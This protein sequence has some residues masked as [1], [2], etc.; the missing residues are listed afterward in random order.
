MNNDQAIIIPHSLSEL[1]MLI[2]STSKD[3]RYV[4]GAT[5]LLVN[6]K[7][8]NKDSTPVDLTAVNE[9]AGTIKSYGSGL[10]IG[11]AVPMSCIIKHPEIRRNFPL[12]TVACSQIGSVQIQNRATLGGNIANASPAGDTLPVL[13]VYDAELMIGPSR[14]DSYKRINLDRMMTAPGQTILTNNRYIAYIYLPLPE[15]PDMFAYF[16]KVGPRHAMAI[17]KVSLAMLCIIRD[18]KVVH[19]RISAGSVTPVIQRAQLTEHFLLG[20]ELNSE[21]IYQARELIRTEIDPID[22]I[23]STRTYR[24]QTCA[25]LLMEALHHAANF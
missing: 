24:S 18:N 13:C 21:T 17:S 6:G 2:R 25:N 12:L 7:W 16:R 9:L 3:I 8:R 11:A 4:A 1:D 5:D 10:L 22:D 23:R 20:K 14:N 19:I 15:Q